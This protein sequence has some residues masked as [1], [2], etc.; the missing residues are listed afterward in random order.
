MDR[1]ITL[2]CMA[3][4]RGLFYG[5]AQHILGMYYGTV[6]SVPVWCLIHQ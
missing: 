4:G 1:H 3:Y 5:A 2:Q 6:R